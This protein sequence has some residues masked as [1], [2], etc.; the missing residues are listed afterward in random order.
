M[1]IDRELVTRKMLLISRDL[2]EL[3]SML[4]ADAQ[5]YRESLRDQAVVERY[6]ER[7]IGRTIDINFHLITESGNAPPSDYYASF[8][9]L[10]DLKILE[11]AFARRIAAAAGLRNRLV[12]DYDRIDPDRVFEALQSALADIPQYIRQVEGFLERR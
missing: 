7:M 5:S 3:R 4:P 10:A 9:Q 6:L 2:E 11:A 8:A 12:H 1:T